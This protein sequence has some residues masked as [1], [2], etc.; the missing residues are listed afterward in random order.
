MHQQLNNEIKYNVGDIVA[1]IEHVHKTLG[2]VVD[3]AESGGW[4][5]KVK[6][7]IL[8]PMFNS[9]TVFHNSIYL[10]KL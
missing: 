9:N 5:I 7:I 1:H 2:I 6:W 3:V 10:I 4:N 8:P